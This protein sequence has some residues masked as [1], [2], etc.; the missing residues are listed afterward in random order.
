MKEQTILIVGG[1]GFIGSHVNKMLHKNGYHT[2]VLDNFSRGHRS[3]VCY[4]TLIEGDL[5]NPLILKH[6]FETYSIQAVMHFA[7]FINVGESVQN[8]AKYYLNNV[9]NTIHLLTTMLKYQVKTFIFS[10]SAAIFG[11]PLTPFIR[12]DHPCTPIN[13]YG[14]SKWMIEKILRDFEAAYHLKF[15]C[16]RYF[17]AAGGDPEGEIKN[18]QTQSSNLIPRL[19]LSLRNLDDAVT[20]YGTDYPTPDGTCIRDFVHLEDLSHAHILAMEKLL[21]GASSN[22]YN[23]GSGRGFS[24]REVIRAVEEALGEKIKM[25]EGPRRL[26]DPPVLLADSSK[27]AAELN[28]KPRYLLS[29]MISHAWKSYDLDG[30][31]SKIYIG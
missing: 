23:L 20:V 29:D 16:L 26:G 27:A 25:I 4:G 1:A 2:L 30:A 3:S 13:P 5:A 14:E 18:Y 8:P 28:W 15:C 7:A 31:N 6:I 11:H 22:Y 12:E 24:V 21:A 9:V 10:S 17:N 19:L